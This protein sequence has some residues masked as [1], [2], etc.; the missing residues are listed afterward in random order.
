MAFE[1]L[2]LLLTANAKDAISGIRE[3]GLATGTLDGKLKTV[4]GSLG[5]VGA[6]AGMTGAQMGSVL[7]GGAIVAGAAIGKFTMDSVNQFVSLADKVRDFSRASGLASEPASRLVAIFDDL[8]VSQAAAD[9][10]FFKLN[11]GIA[12]GSVHLEDYGVKVARAKDGTLDAYGTLLNLADAYNATEDSGKRAAMVQEA[13][14]RGG[15]ELIPILERGRD[16]LRELYAAVPDRQILSDDQ[17]NQAREYELAVDDL[18]DSFQELQYAVAGEVIPTLTSF[19]VGGA[20]TIRFLTDAKAGVEGFAGGLG[21]TLVDAAEKSIPGIGQLKGITDGLG[22]AFGWGG[23]ESD[24]FTDSQKRLGEAQQN[25]AQLA[26]DNTTKAS[27]L[28]AAK[29]ELRAA[30]SE[31]EGVMGRVNAALGDN[32]SKLVENMAAAQELTNAQLGLTGAELNVE[33][34]TVKY[35]ETLAENGAESL[36]TRQAAQNLE[37]QYV[38]LGNATFAAAIQQGASQEE[39]AARQVN[40][41]SYVAGTLAPGSPL[42]VFLDQYISRLQSTPREI[43]TVLRLTTVAEEYGG[44]SAGVGFRGYSEGGWVG[45]SGT[46]DT[47][48]AMLTPGEFVVSKDM[49]AGRASMPAGVGGGSG[50]VLNATI[51]APSGNGDDIVE[52]LARWVNNNGAVPSRVKAAFA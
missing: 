2:E 22:K 17:V 20:G 36:V 30:E 34:A 29:R 50:V 45:G 27:E 16:G 8:E 4:E 13:F 26:A 19:A 43:Q 49:L 1:R 25:L 23:E 21:G 38:A 33:A 18:K 39:A 15:K 46:G 44:G 9:T 35:N 11:R 5:K 6:L 37:Q 31:Y 40:A 12:D 24:K 41:L 28:T 32:T 10:G 47:V 52:A 48:P 7:A 42:R 3:T 14:G 51:Y